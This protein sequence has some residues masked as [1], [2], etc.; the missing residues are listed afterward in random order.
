MAGTKRSPNQHCRSLSVRLE[1]LGGRGKGGERRGI[2][3]ER[4]CLNR[5][6]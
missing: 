3:V 2:S 5:Y 4:V 1:K 6:Y